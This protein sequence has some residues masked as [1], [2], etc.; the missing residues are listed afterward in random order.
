MHSF[1]WTDLVCL[2]DFKAQTQPEKFYM[3]VH[4]T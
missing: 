1:D 3:S 2:S 4:I